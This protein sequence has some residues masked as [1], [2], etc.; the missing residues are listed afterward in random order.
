MRPV[1]ATLALALLTLAAGCQSAAPHPTGRVSSPT[2]AAPTLEAADIAFFA[3]HY[4]DAEKQYLSLLA[5]DPQSAVAHAHYALFLNYGHRFVEA[6][7]QVEEAVALAP[8]DGYVLAVATRVKDWSANSD[9]ELMAAA[10][11]GA[12]AVKTAPQLALAHVFY[13]ET[14]ADTGQDAQALQQLA[15]AEQ[16]VGGDAYLRAEVERER[17]NLARDQGDK[18]AEIQHLLASRARQPGWAERTREV[19]EYYFAND[20]VD[21]AVTEFRSA[22]ALA[23]DDADLRV[24]LGDVAME[25]Q[26]LSLADEAFAA[27]DKLKP[28]VAAIEASL[29][30]AGFNVHRDSAGTERLLRAAVADDPKA[31]AVAMLLEGFLRYIERNAAAADAVAATGPQDE[32]QPRYRSRSTRTLD[33][34]RLDDAGKALAAV[35]AA[36]ARA[37]LAPA[38]LDPVI[39]ESAT[40]HAYWWIFNLTLPQT[41]DL[42]IHQEVAGTPG[43]TGVTM[44]DRATRFGY[45]RASM[46][47]DITHRGEPVSAVA[48]WVDSVYHRFP[49]MRADLDG[50]GFGEG[51]ITTLPIDVMDMSYTDATGDVRQ[52]TPYP[53]DGQ[54]E[55]PTAF[56]GNELPDP[57][58]K[59]GAYPTGYPV[60]V[61]FN[62][63]ARV[64]I[65]SWTITDPQG[66]SFDAYVIN[67]GPSSENVLS[68]LPKQPLAPGTRYTVHLG[69]AINGSPFALAWSFVTKA[70]TTQA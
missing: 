66:R 39:Q 34:V 15:M 19:A 1:R 48:D 24:S 40:S 4:S 25:R 38:H 30:V 59:G 36:R 14:L 31:T 49:L 27:A 50:V 23:P 54:Q 21:Q 5:H 47:E 7:S 44:R 29:A 37:H 46:A 45:H 9:E 3:N 64:S 42:G 22:I 58:P 20:Q 13:S 10:A 11:A 68:L 55:V 67:P 51:E 53:A 62:P 35:N 57:V 56:F 2:P 28:H 70:P 33:D 63:A 18:A 26:D 52:M 65:A 61:N 6:R 60:T 41:K 17:A 32:L 16:L 69:G 43:Y 12:L 8:K